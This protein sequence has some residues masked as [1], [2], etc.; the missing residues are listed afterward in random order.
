MNID[1]TDSTLSPEPLYHWFDSF[2]FHLFFIKKAKEGEL[3]V[4]E[5]T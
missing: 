1:P 4:L 5:Y 2:S 3:T